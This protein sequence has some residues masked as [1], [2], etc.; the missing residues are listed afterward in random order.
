MALTIRNGKSSMALISLNTISSV[1][2]IIL[3]GRRISQINGSKN[4]RTNAKGQHITNKMHQ[5]I[6]ARRVLMGFLKLIKQSSCQSVNLRFFKAFAVGG[7]ICIRNCTLN[8]PN[9][10]RRYLPDSVFSIR[11]LKNSQP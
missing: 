5:R 10:Y 2:P 9:A 11:D 3:K 1:N 4:T 6:M 7:I 8:W